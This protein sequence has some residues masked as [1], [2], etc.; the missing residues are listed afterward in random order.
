MSDELTAERVDRL[1]AGAEPAGLAEDHTMRVLAQLR[2]ASPPAPPA[3]RERV[4]VLGGAPAGDRA[5]RSG[6]RWRR[7]LVPATLSAGTATAAVIAVVATVGGDEGS[8]PADHPSPPRAWSASEAPRSGDTSERRPERRRGRGGDR[9]ALAPPV[10]QLPSAPAVPAPS[11]PRGCTGDARA[12]SSAPLAAAATWGGRPPAGWQEPPAGPVPDPPESAQPPAGDP[13]PAP[14]AAPPETPQ[15]GSPGA[16][17]E[18]SPL[19]PA[20]PDG[21]HANERPRARERFPRP[22][23][24]PSTGC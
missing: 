10:K 3:L 17:Q 13:E 5:A 1:L 20:Q 14:E 9:L 8:S 21:A 7:W 24:G 4:G 18:S 12:A 22:D 23:A 11:A 19:Q 16:E 6:H 15:G 2:E